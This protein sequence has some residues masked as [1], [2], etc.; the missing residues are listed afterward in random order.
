MGWD[1][2]P[3]KAGCLHI[4]PP[5]YWGVMLIIMIIVIIMMLP[6]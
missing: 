1:C 4:A 2:S 5:A 6:F 3:E